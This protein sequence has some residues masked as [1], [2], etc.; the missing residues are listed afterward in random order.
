M[1]S[2]TNTLKQKNII[3]LD[4]LEEYQIMNKKQKLEKK[5]MATGPKD[6]GK[7]TNFSIIHRQNLY[8]TFIH[9]QNTEET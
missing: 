2:P 9:R 5:I 7:N 4:Y 3:H 6:K 8:T 1:S